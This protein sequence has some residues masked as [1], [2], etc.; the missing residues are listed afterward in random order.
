[1]AGMDWFRWHHGS[2]TD[3]KFQLVARKTK[4]SVAEVISVWAFILEFGS[5]NGASVSA[6][7]ATDCDKLLGFDA[8]RSSR[9]VDGLVARG[10]ISENRIASPRRYFPSPSMRPSGGVWA[11]VRAFIFERD[12]YT[13]QYCGTRCAKL[14]CDHI[15]PV[16]DGGRHTHDNLCTAC[17]NCNRSKASQS[18][19]AW[20]VKR[21][22]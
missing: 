16:A 15:T 6:F 3:P 5:K 17:F 21:G 12:D 11:Q 10:L 8:G 20:E 19:A 22:W 7:S 1:M 18:L 14:E 9:I 2:V 4:S 13:C